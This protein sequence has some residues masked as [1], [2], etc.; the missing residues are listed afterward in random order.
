M[1]VLVLRSNSMAELETSFG[2]GRV[3]TGTDLLAFTWHFQ[4]P[5]SFACGLLIV[6][7]Q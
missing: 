2:S 1:L 7:P 6:S 4:S 3:I 5:V